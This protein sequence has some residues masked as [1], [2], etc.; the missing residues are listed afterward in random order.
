MNLEN[1]LEN[2]PFIYY[3]NLDNRTDRREYMESQFKKWNIKKYARVSGSK[4]LGSKVSEWYHLVKG[5]IYMQGRMPQVTA[6]AMSHIEFFRWWLTFTDDQHL[7]IMED[8]CDL[9]LIEYWHFDWNYL[10]KHIP[11]DWDCIQLGYESQIQIQFFLSPK[12]PYRTYFGPCL[13]NR[14]YVEKLVDLHFKDG[15]FIFDHQVNNYQL[16]VEG[17][18]TTVDY[19]IGE[20]GRTYCIPLLTVNN[21]LGSYED[22]KMHIIDH[23]VR[24]R[25][26]YY[27]W[28]QNERDNFSLEDFFVYG[29]PYDNLMTKLV[30]PEDYDVK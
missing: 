29:K 16:L 10:M 22:N 12:Q 13:L 9:D 17:G 2:L 28:W 20:N 4:Y 24:S 15:F 8:D 30:Y 19:F 11:Y 27:H 23:H 5:A 14:R 25:N 6:N 21:D 18:S 3:F 26:L 1:K 7:I